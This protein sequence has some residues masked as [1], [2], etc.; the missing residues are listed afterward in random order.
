MIPIDVHSLP[1]S[2]SHFISCFS[3]VPLEPVANSFVHELIC[4]SKRD[5]V[6]DD[7]RTAKNTPQR[8]TESIPYAVRVSYLC[9]DLSFSPLTP[10]HLP[11]P[12]VTQ[13]KR[14]TLKD[15]LFDARLSTLC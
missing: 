15:T 7:E 6:C 14:T 2:S 12:H 10:T 3:P 11:K 8:F 9:D 1:S 5:S 13:T 4:R